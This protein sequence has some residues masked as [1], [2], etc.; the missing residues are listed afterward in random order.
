MRKLNT[1]VVAKFISASEIAASSA[2]D[3]RFQRV[4]ISQYIM[5]SSRAEIHSASFGQ[6]CQKIKPS[7]VVM[8]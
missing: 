3:A 7:S 1:A 8:V 6:S 2:C 5:R 4:I